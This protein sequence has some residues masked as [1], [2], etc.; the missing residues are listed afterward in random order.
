MFNKILGCLSMVAIG[1]ALGMPSHDMTIDQIKHFFNGT[2][3][4]FQPPPGDSRVHKGFK[5]G[6]VTDD[7]LLTLSLSDAYIKNRG[8]IS[9]RIIAAMTSTVVT[10]Y[11]NRGL[12]KMFGPSTKNSVE[13]FHKGE[14]P[15]TMFMGENHPTMGTSNGGAMKIS[16]VGLV[17]PGD[18]EGVLED[19]LKVCLPSHGTQTAISAASAIAAG[20]SEAMD[21]GADV[22]SVVRSALRGAEKG[23]VMGRQKARTVPLPSVSKR[24]KLAVSIALEADDIETAN[25]TFSEMIGTGLAAYESIP[26]A[27]GI[28]VAC[29]GDPLRCVIAGANVGFDTDT[30]AAMAGALAGT[31]NG[32]DKVPGELF[33]KVEAANHLNLEKVAADLEKLIVMEARHWT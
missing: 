3:N 8:A 4:D 22:F 27:I 32:F 17:H 33:R 19:T 7:T 9:S 20:V 25:R 2:L 31:L 29:G 5:A 6:Q 23:E 21:P 16:P 12:D 11:S 10:E 15:E 26:T 1:D 24:I 30:I 28:F 13:R 14:D 18:F